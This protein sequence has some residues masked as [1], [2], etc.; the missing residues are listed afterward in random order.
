MAI[1][2]VLTINDP[3]NVG[4]FPPDVLASDWYANFFNVA[5]FQ[6]LG[7]NTGYTFSFIFNTQDDLNAWVT[8]NALDPSL[9]AS[10]DRWKGFGVSYENNFYTLPA[11]SGTGIIN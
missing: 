11:T 5:S 6:G 4:P 1:L 3:S 8:A 2:Y 9:Q 7:G 10:I